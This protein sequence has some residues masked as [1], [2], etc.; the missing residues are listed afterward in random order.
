M[1]SRDKILNYMENKQFIAAK[2]LSGFLGISRQAVNKHLK[3]LIQRG[4]IVKQ[5]TTRGTVYQFAA[6]AGGL[7]QVAK[8]IKKTLLLS[9]LEEDRVFR[10]LTQF[11]NLKKALGKNTFD[12]AYYA[13]TEML[14]NAIDHSESGK[15]NVEVTLDQYKFNFN[16]RDFGIGIFYSIFS[17]LRLS[18]ENAAIGELIKGKTTTM[19]EKHTGEGIFFTSK[20]SDRIVFRSHNINMIFDNQ[21]K[22]IYVEEKKHIKGTEVSFSISRRTKKRLNRIFSQYAPKEFDYTFQRTRALVKLFHKN[23]VSRSEAKR[24]LYGLDKFREITLDFKGVTSIGQGFADEIFRVFANE[25]PDIKVETVNISP[26]L[27]PVIKHVVDKRD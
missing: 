6:A 16:I 12:I 13:F 4:K 1:N 18:D 2:E 26:A 3:A 8:K 5:G 10:E 7:P 21:K 15:C 17:K 27:Q 23:Y 9:G 14:N 20:A 11:L 24:L 19:K 25:H 22:D